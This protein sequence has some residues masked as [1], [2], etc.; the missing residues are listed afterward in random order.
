M[1]PLQN[2]RNHDRETH[3]GSHRAQ[4][5][6]DC[7][8]HTPTGSERAARE[9]SRQCPDRDARAEGE[10]RELCQSRGKRTRELERHDADSHQTG[11]TRER[12]KDRGALSLGSRQGAQNV[13][14]GH[15]SDRNKQRNDAEHVTPTPYFGDV[16]CDRGANQRR[17]DPCQGERC[18]ERRAMTGRR[19]R[20]NKDIE[21]NDQEAAS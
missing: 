21:R 13:G 15:S 19:N 2:Q 1:Y 12:R 17:Q 9:E 7:R 11:V 4:P 5:C 20:S 6:E 18:E 16:S 10:D 14:D 3:L 8:R